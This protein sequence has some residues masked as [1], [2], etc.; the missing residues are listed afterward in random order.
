V[1]NGELGTKYRL[2]PLLDPADVLPEEANAING[3]RHWNCVAIKSIRLVGKS[4]KPRIFETDA[5]LAAIIE[6]SDDA[7]ISKTVDGI[8]TSW[9][10]G[11]EKMFGCSA[12]GAIGQHIAFIIPPE[13]RSEEDDVLAHVRRGEKVDH[14]E[15]V[16][17]AEDGRQVD[18][19]LAVSPVMDAHGQIIGASKV[20][21][22][23][24]ARKQADEERERLTEQAQVARRYAE[25]ANSIGVRKLDSSA[26]PT[27]HRAPKRDPKCNRFPTSG[28]SRLGSFSTLSVHNIRKNGQ[29]KQH[30]LLKGGRR[31]RL[32]DVRRAQWSSIQIQT[33]V[34]ESLDH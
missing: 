15:T 30:S 28:R 25:E 9:N 17:Q 8:I 13:R 21:R 2:S 16:R 14:F 23:I 31:V 11:A 20:A 7:I 19:S 10:P 29:N 6:S 24:S 4:M 26:R 33:S 34:C 12:A 5:L 32:P 3:F 27:H 1:H 18:I 22:D